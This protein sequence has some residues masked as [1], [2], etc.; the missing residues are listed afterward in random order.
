MLQEFSEETR[1]RGHKFLVYM[2]PSSYDLYPSYPESLEGYDRLVRQRWLPDID[3][4]IQ[5]HAFYHERL[6]AFMRQASIPFVDGYVG[7]RQRAAQGDRLYTSMLLP[8]LRDGHL[9]P[10][11]HYRS[12]ELIFNGLLAYHHL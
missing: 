12:A 7:L 8:E 5:V 11:G 3:A 9:S 2:I 4:A 10:L 6:V 1:K